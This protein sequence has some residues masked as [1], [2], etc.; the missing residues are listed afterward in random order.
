[1]GQAT[2]QASSWELRMPRVSQAITRWSA[3]SLRRTFSMNY[4]TLTARSVTATL[5]VCGT[6]G[7]D[8]LW[9]LLM[10]HIP[11]SSNCPEVPR[12]VREDGVYFIEGLRMRR[13]RRTRS[14]AEVSGSGSR[15]RNSNTTQY[16]EK[17][18]IAVFINLIGSSEPGHPSSIP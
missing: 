17:T 10:T 5:S 18:R 16:V 4:R 6:A 15:G 1:L 12:I 9:N 3:G 11:I 13:R 14:G 8:D 2:I 7:A